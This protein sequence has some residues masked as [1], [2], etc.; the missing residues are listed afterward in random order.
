MWESPISV[1]LEKIE[2]EYI[3]E[4]ERYIVQ[5][6]HWI[7]GIKV[8]KEELVKALSYDRSQYEKGYAD[9]KKDAVKHG[10][11]IVDTAF[12]NDVMSGEQMVICSE[13]GKGIFWGKQ[14]YC[15]NC[16]AKMDEVSE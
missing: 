9:G 2:R 4:Q 6:T 8:D 16:G 15:P 14:N 5:E 12:G 10:R 7:T 1:E 3:D 13:C 11:W